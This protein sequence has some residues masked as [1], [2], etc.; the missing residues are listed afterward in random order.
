MGEL[1]KPMQDPG[2]IPLITVQQ[3]LP[4]STLSH[5]FNITGGKG[6]PPKLRQDQKVLPLIVVHP[7]PPGP[8]RSADPTAPPQDGGSFDPSPADG[9]PLSP[10]HSL[11]RTPSPFG[12]TPTY[13][14][15]PYYVP[16]RRLRMPASPQTANF[17]H[18][19]P[20]GRCQ[21][22]PMRVRA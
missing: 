10:P 2:V 21:H 13:D 19:R 1:P 15:V 16:P 22:S 6:E 11:T 4:Y 14:P 18:T 17:H 8:T 3:P 5:S 7:S 12:Y 20:T 9:P